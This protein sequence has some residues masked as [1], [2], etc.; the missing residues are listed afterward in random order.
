MP[1]LT[2]AEKAANVAAGIKAEKAAVAA[3]EARRGYADLSEKDAGAFKMDQT[4]FK[5]RDGLREVHN[6][7]TERPVPFDNLHEVAT[8]ACA[9]ETSLVFARNLQKELK[10]GPLSAAR[11]A[12][13]DAMFTRLSEPASVVFF[14]GPPHPH[15]NTIVFG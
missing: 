2:K 5:M 7:L 14:G 8:L 15:K 9:L 1:R 10:R 6:I 12:E 13:L 4:F 3:H 11:R